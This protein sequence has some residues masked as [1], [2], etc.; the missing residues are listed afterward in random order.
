MWRGGA[1]K[2]C[3]DV[4]VFGKRVKRGTGVFEIGEES[5]KKRNER[6]LFFWRHQSCVRFHPTA[7]FPF[8]GVLRRSGEKGDQ[9]EALAE[10]VLALDGDGDWAN[11]NMSTL[12]RSTASA[13]TVRS[14]RKKRCSALYKLSWKIKPS[15]ASDSIDGEGGIGWKMGRMNRTSNLSSASW[16]SELTGG[17]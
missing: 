15:K 3:C 1:V 17:R 12:R 13:L 4:R 14:R 5:K 6:K 16:P 2:F 11:R 7:R 9:T 10:D 8:H